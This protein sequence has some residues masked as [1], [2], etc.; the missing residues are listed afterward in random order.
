MK[1][2]L[3]IAALAASL[4]TL[5]V[6][7]TSED[8]QAIVA[9]KNV[10]F[11][12]SLLRGDANA[13]AAAFAADGEILSPLE[14]IIRGR[15][16]ILKKYTTTLAAT[17]FTQVSLQTSELRTGGDTAYE[18]GRFTMHFKDSSN[19]DLPEALTGRYVRIWHRVGN[20]WLI[21]VDAVQPGAPTP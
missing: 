18:I 15:A 19:S 21:S 11:G 12:Q 7:R 5:A 13:C 14:P 3:F 17:T 2:F 16:A 20:D 6:A 8:V 1:V 9:R 4:G 10:A